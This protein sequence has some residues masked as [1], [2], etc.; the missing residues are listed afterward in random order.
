M[1]SRRAVGDRR[2]PYLA[3][4]T[5]PTNELT[6]MSPAAAQLIR[7]N[8]SS[9]KDSA[10]TMLTTSES[11]FFAAFMRCMLSGSSAPITPISRMPCAAV[12]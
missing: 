6:A 7:S 8:A 12:K 11:R 9:V 4:T 1:H 2:R 3:P 5:P 10:A